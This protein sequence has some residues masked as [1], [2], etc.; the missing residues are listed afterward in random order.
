MFFFLGLDCD[1]DSVSV[2]SSPQFNVIL[3]SNQIVYLA[4][5]CPLI[6]NGLWSLSLLFALLFWSSSKCGVNGKSYDH[7]VIEMGD[8]A[9]LFPLYVSLPLFSPKKIQGYH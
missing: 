3:I 4:F 2:S 5:F 1:L 9:F 8:M 7:N 6:Y